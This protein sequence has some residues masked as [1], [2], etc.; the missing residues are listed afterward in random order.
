MLNVSHLLVTAGDY[1]QQKFLV[2][3]SYHSR[4]LK[5]Q[6]SRLQRTDIPFLES[7]GHS[8]VIRFAVWKPASLCEVMISSFPFSH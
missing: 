4:L 3:C 1:I 5:R 6:A 2:L 7:L 8:K